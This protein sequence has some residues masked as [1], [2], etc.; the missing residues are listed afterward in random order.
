MPS[1]DRFQQNGKE[2]NEKTHMRIK[3]EEEN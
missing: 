2:I 3:I 1:S